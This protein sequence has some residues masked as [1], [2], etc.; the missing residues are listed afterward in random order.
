MDDK[1]NDIVNIEGGYRTYSSLR[2]VQN[3]SVLIIFGFS[4]FLYIVDLP[5][6]EKVFTQRQNL[7]P[8]ICDKHL[9][10]IYILETC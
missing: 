10:L 1:V 2:P 8:V 3:L 4:G 7:S 5:K 6:K 9:A